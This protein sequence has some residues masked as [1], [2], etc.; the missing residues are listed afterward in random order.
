MPK[1][2]ILLITVDQWRADCLGVAGHPVLRT[3]TVDRL[4]AGGVRFRRHYAVASPCGPSRASLLTGMYACNHRSVTNGT[5]LDARFTNLAKEVR[6]AGY[7]PVLFGYTDTSIDPRGLDPADPRLTTYEGLLPGF[8][9]GL[10][11]DEASAPWLEWLAAK[12]YPTGE[13]SYPRVFDPV[14]GD[15]PAGRK[16]DNRPPIYPAAHS[17]TRFL[18]D[19]TI[20]WL[21]GRERGW[22][23][24]LSL[25]RPHPPWIAPE[26]Y[27][28]AHDPA[29]CPP[30]RRAE[31]AA[32]EGEQHPLLMAL[33]ARRDC[34]DFFAADGPVAELCDADVAQARATYYGLIEKVDAELARLFGAVDLDETLVV[35][36]S[37]HGEMLGDHHLMGKAGYFDQ[38]FHIP[39][40]VRGPGVARG[41]VDAFTESVDV[42]P[43]LLAYIGLAVPTQVD[44]CSLL[45]WLRGERPGGWR[46]AAHWEFDFRDPREA[47]AERHFGLP[48][49]LCNL[50]AIRSASEK[51]VHFAG[52]P[53][54][55]FDLAADPDEL[56]DLATDPTRSADVL[57]CAQALLS[58]RMAHHERTLANMSLG[59]GGVVEALP[60]G[61][62][63]VLAD[64]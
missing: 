7:R 20:D 55:Y 23:V 63:S 15:L 48:P 29:A 61:R 16:L 5:P 10:Q 46:D 58:W 28:T 54:L 11:L 9:V 27:N 47:A 39:L 12:G 3:P 8:D 13:L 33:L 37:D 38:A 41:A 32:V 35:V 49:E 4:A 22:F 44:G 1:Q 43:T 64:T 19:A 30:P 59:E 45:P 56:R 18:V 42:M 21:R 52:L 60:A 2:N 50:T 24:H 26:P 57:R 25:L 40:I 6:H 17:P 36:T 31:S 14:P 34:R 53:P 62:K 51:Y